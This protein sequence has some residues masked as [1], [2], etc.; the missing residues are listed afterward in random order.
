MK[1]RSKLLTGFIT[2]AITFSI[3]MVFA[4]PLYAER[5][6]NHSCGQKNKQVNKS[7]D[8]TDYKF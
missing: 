2:A 6:N 7:T 3:L 5:K 1:T 4:K 8:T